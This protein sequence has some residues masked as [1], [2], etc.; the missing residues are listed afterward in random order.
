MTIQTA[1]PPT[2][3]QS[4]PVSTATIRREPLTV[5][6]MVMVC[7]GLFVLLIAVAMIALSIGSVQISLSHVFGALTGSESIP[8]TEQTIILSLRLPGC[9]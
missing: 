2:I 8:K 7:T 4:I 9:E 1:E 6:R 3:K 5:Q